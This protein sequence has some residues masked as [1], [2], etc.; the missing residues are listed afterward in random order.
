[1]LKKHLLK[2]HKNNLRLTIHKKMLRLMIH[3]NKLKLIIN[4]HRF[5]KIKKMTKAVIK[6]LLVRDKKRVKYVNDKE[7]SIKIR[8]LK[9]LFSNDWNVEQKKYFNQDSEKTRYNSNKK[10]H[11]E[12]NPSEVLLREKIQLIKLKKKQ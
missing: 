11:L 9:N 12:M 2:K 10:Q 8:K 5:K 6:A 3:K 1:M 7:K 4:R